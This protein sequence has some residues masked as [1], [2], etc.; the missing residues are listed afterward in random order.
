MKE[1]DQKKHYRKISLKERYEII[2]MVCVEKK[3][4]AF[5][6]RKLDISPSTVKM[7]ALKYMEEGTLF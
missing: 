3:T 5:A 7:I 6:S 2:Q 4:Y 1:E